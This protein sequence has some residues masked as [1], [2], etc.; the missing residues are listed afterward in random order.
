M[1][2]DTGHNFP[3]TIQY[4][5][6]LMEKTGAR[7]IVKYVQDT[8]D[9]GKAVEETGVNA[10]RNKIQTITLLDAIEQEKFDA[11]MGVDAA[12][13]KKH[14]PKSASFLIVMS[15]VSGTP[16]ISVPNS[17]TCLM[18]RRIWGSISVFFRSV[19]G[20]RWMCGS[21]FTWRRLSCHR[22]TLRTKERCF[23][24]TVHGWQKPFYAIERR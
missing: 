17:G 11:A 19:T 22:F 16:R 6:D 14:V 23:S 7:C 21:T 18:V 3:E 1:H 5:D 9:Q 24:V 20:P 8:I 13:K 2:I 15:L 10:S 12:M 4:R